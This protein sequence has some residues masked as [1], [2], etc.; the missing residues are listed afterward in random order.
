M[1][2]RVDSDST[3]VVFRP[4]PL[5]TFQIAGGCLA[6]V[7]VCAALF[8]QGSTGR[9]LGSITDQ[10]GAVIPGVAVTIR[11]VDRGTSRTLI[12]DEAGIYNAPN[13]LPGTYTLRMELAG[14][15]TV[16]RQNIKLEVGQDI[17]IDVALRP[18][19]QTELVTVQAESPLVETNNAELGGTI[20]N[21][22]INDLPL[23]G[24]NFE[25]LLDLRPG[26]S[27]YPGN[28]GWTNS[29]NGGRPHD[30]YFMVDGINSN[31]TWMAQSMMNAV[32]AAG[33]AGTMLPI[34]AINEFKT[35]QNPGGEYG[36]KP[37]AVVNVGVKSGTNAMHGTAYAY[38]RN[39]AWDARNFFLTQTDPQSD[40]E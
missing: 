19:Q 7:L 28:S 31:D 4:R 18:G 10:T 8:S 14:F 27:K 2:V 9:I 22:A 21:A 23:N 13:L 16:E 24:R 1:E 30:N 5:N 35:Q 6:I 12:T 40:V 38:G 32:M 25:N 39:S 37:G 29:T 15:A 33:D 36:W 11:D 26:V 34:D 20:A 3:F 17:R